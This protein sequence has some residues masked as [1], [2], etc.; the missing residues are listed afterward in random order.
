MPTVFVAYP[1]SISKADYRGVY[2]QITNEFG[3]QFTYAD[4]EITNKHILEKIGR[5]MSEADFGLFDITYWNPN[6]ALELGLAIGK[7]YEYYILWNPTVD[8]DKPPSDIGGID[9]IEYKDYA[10]LGAG[11][12]ALMTQQFGAPDAEETPQGKVVVESIDALRDT[13]SRV[14]GGTPGIAMGGIA[15]SLGVPVDLAQIVVKPLV[16]D[17]KIATRGARRGTRYYLPDDAPPEEEE[18]EEE[19]DLTGDDDEETFTIY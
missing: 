9:R 6:V 12:Q 19:D 11:L 15:S 17:K 14:V 4:E 2:T 13:V 10:Q 3:V 7:G 18:E 5:M 1:Y 16:N 8:Q